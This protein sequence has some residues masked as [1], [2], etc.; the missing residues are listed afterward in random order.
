MHISQHTMPGVM[1]LVSDV[2]KK[3]FA[4]PL[5]F[6][7][8]MFASGQAQKLSPSSESTAKLEVVTS[9]HEQKICLS[10]P[11]TVSA[12]LALIVNLRMQ[13]KTHSLF[14]EIAGE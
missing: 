5:A 10:D 6:L 7:L 8:L 13:V 4:A 9:I 2:T 12:D 1:P 11:E 3:T 14:L